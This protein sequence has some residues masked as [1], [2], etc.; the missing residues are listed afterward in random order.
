MSI[1]VVTVGQS[2]ED[3]VGGLERLHGPVTVVRRCSELTELLAACQSGLARAAVVAEGSDELTASL[4]DR[5]AAVGVVIV[6]LTDSASETARLT[7]I[8]VTAAPAGVDSAT[9]AGRISG[10]VDQ[11]SRPEPFQAGDSGFADTGAA[12][13]TQPV[14]WKTTFQQ[15]RPAPASLLPSGVR[16]GRPA[17]R[18]WRQTWQASWLQR[19]IQSS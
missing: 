8:G 18:S 12:I 17:G 1:P 15:N 14:R 11:W 5:L 10:A 6:A 7:A 9:L 4:V 2:S 13:R 19:A 3:L 16:Q